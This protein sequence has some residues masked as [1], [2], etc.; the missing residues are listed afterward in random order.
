MNFSCYPPVN[1]EIQAWSSWLKTYYEMIR[2]LLNIGSYHY[3]PEFYSCWHNYEMRWSFLEWH[4]LLFSHCHIW[5]FATSLT[6]AHQA[7]LSS[8]VSWSLLRF[9]S[10]ELVML[11]HHHYL[12]PLLSPFAFDLSQHQGLFQWVGS[13]HQ[14]A[15]VWGASASATVLMNIQGWF[16]LGLTG[17]I[18]LLSK[19]LSRVFSN[20]IIQKHQFFW[21]T[22]FFIQF[23]HLYMTTGKKTIASI[24]VFY[25]VTLRRVNMW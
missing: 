24:I 3:P 9:M 22:A 19:G 1:I 15:N 11:S 5:L 21:H 12:V 10:I 20:T 13:L 4:L 2:Q 17:L 8:T 6:V 16:P 23:S 18:S 14:M 7:P 25:R